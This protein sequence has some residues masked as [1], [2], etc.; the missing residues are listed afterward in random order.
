MVYICCKIL[1][2]MTVNTVITLV[3]LDIVVIC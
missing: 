1:C 2:C 3:V